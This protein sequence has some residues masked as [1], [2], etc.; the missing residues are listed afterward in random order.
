MDKVENIEFHV[1]ETQV[2][3]D[4]E[5]FPHVCMCFLVGYFG[6][7]FTGP[8]HEFA[9]RLAHILLATPSAFNAVNEVG[10]FA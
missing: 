3:C 2:W 5:I 6:K 10:A 8:S 1:L 4:A 9:L 7:V